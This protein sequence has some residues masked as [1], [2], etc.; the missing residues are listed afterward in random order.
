MYVSSTANILQACNQYN[1]CLVLNL[2]FISSYCLKW[3]FNRPLSTWWG[4]IFER[5]VGLVKRCLK[6][7]RCDNRLRRTW[8]SF[9][10]NRI[11]FKQSTD[12]LCLWK[13]GEQLL[14][15]SRHWPQTLQYQLTRAE[16]SIHTLKIDLFKSLV[17]FRNRWNR[18][19]LLQLGGHFK[20]KNEKSW[21]TCNKSD[22][23]FVYEP[24]KKEQ[25]LKQV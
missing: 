3:H 2:S 6:R 22:F 12:N 10:W 15:P 19:Y 16:K 1:L 21:D 7:L 18:E 11:N 13:I 23:L 14:T 25:I 17:D 20:Y 24:N 4:G 9:A 5:M 8:D